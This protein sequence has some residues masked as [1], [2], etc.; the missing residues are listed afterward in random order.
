MSFALH[1]TLCTHRESYVQRWA[2]N[3]RNALATGRSVKCSIS[4]SIWTQVQWTCVRCSSCVQVHLHRLKPLRTAHLHR[5][6][7][8]SEKV[9]LRYLSEV[10]SQRSLPSNRVPVIIPF[11]LTRAIIKPRIVRVR[12]V[13]GIRL[14]RFLCFL[15]CL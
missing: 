8:F 2:Q 7:H 12:I 1:N 3:R 9:S 5:D 11:V 13:S 15:T 14:C 6:Q 10:C 4:W